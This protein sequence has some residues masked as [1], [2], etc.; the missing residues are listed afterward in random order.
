MSPTS[1]TFVRE[2]EAPNY[3]M[4]SVDPNRSGSFQLLR[5]FGNLD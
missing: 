1:R 2:L 5:H 3:D 4:G